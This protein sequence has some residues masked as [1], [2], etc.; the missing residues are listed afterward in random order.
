[1][2]LLKPGFYRFDILILFC[3]QMCHFFSIQQIFP[4]FLKYTPKTACDGDYCFAMPKSNCMADIK[5]CNKTA[6]PDLC[7]SATTP[8]AKKE[9]V[10]KNSFAYYKSAAMEYH[11]FCDH[12]WWNYGPAFAQY[13]GV[14]L[15]NIVLGHVADKWGRKKTFI[16]SLLV[17]I[18]ALCL[19]ATFDSLPVF[20]AFRALTGVGIAGTMIVGWA[21]FSELVSPHQRFKLRVF[22]NWANAR[23][24]LTLVCLFTGEWRL[25]SYVSAAITCIT[26]AIA[27]FVLPESHIWLKKKGRFAE[28]EASR[29][30]IAAISGVEFV[31]QPAPELKEG[32]LPP[33]PEKGVTILNVFQDPT[34]R[35]NLLVLWVMWFV[36]GM[37][38]YL[39]DLSGGDMTKNFWIGQF[40]SGI[41]LSA[42][43][44]IL[45]FADGSLP[46]MG[47]RFVLLGAQSLAVFFFLCVI[48]FL[49]LGQKVII[50]SKISIISLELRVNGTIL[51]CIWVLSCSRRLSGSR[52]TCVLLN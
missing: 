23:I 48:G 8:A 14:L 28:A 27:I 9:C 39:T 51:P 25:S 13:S 43:R 35:R 46:W 40:L 2:Q 32:E 17:G 21:F 34:L 12:S 5:A 20:F 47:R 10:E 37:T 52:A 7:A 19:S 1:M 11:Y 38:A 6:C 26:L 33:E 36:I 24:M 22:S 44:I 18:P 29:R 3:Y 45:G 49:F 41:L 4:V 31:P 16:F 50:I 15:G 42:V 30:R